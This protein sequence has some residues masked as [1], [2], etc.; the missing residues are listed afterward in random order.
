MF[1]SIL[2]IFNENNYDTV[3]RK[4]GGEGKKGKFYLKKYIFVCQI[5][6]KFIS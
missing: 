6:A 3:A 1:K 2:L 4:R 5:Y